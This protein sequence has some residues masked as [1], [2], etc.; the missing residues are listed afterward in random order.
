MESY[1]LANDN[2]DTFHEMYAKNREFWAQFSTLI[3]ALS[4][5]RYVTIRDHLEV[6]N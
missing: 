2:L 6:H 1:L 5:R 4:Y 3:W